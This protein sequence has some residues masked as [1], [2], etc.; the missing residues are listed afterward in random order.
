MKIKKWMI[1]TLAA[2]LI[3]AMFTGCG[4]NAGATMDAMGGDGYYDRE[5]LSNGIYE[6]APSVDKG[7]VESGNQIQQNQK[8]IKTVYLTTE[9]EDM[10]TLLQ[11]I[12]TRVSELGG[13]VESRSVRNGSDYSSYR[14]RSADFIS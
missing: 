4:A 7:T 11:G 3:L 13:Y 6:D 1:L 2:A 8:L 12:D 14:S 10:D 9:T 5:E